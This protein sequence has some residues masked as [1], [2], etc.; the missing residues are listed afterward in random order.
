MRVQAFTLADEI[1][2]DRG[3]FDGVGIFTFGISFPENKFPV[4]TEMPFAMLLCRENADAEQ[5]ATLRTRLKTR[6]GVAV[7]GPHND[8]VGFTFPAEFRF[9]M[10]HGTMR[11]RFQAPGYYRLEITADADEA[12]TDYLYEFLIV[13]GPP[14]Q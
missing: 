11:F 6:A 1:N 12:P 10:V 7:E 9:T 5:A 4:T 3:R 2:Q 14:T 13:A 8:T